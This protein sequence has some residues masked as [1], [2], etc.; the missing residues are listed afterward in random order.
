MT[1]LDLESFV[2]II[3]ASLVLVVVLAVL[4]IHFYLTP[5][6]ILLGLGT[7]GFFGSAA[8]LLL[9]LWRLNR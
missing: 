1:P 7:V 9:G 4:C 6:V 3:V 2:G 5:L 8:Y